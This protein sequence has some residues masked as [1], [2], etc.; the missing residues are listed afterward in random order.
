MIANNIKALDTFAQIVHARNTA[1]KIEEKTGLLLLCHVDVASQILAFCKPNHHLVMLPLFASRKDTFAT[2]YKRACALCPDEYMNQFVLANMVPNKKTSNV[3][4]G[5]SIDFNVMVSKVLFTLWEWLKAL[6]LGL[7]QDDESQ[8]QQIVLLSELHDVPS[9][10]H[11]YPMIGY[12]GMFTM[13][14]LNEKFPDPT[15]SAL[16]GFKQATKLDLECVTS[17]EM[18]YLLVE[19]QLPCVRGSLIPVKTRLHAH[20]AVLMN[21]TC[22]VEENSLKANTLL[23]RPAAVALEQEQLDEQLEAPTLQE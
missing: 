21:K 20:L 6:V 1:P 3:S 23:Y 13:S 12:S 5:T 15:E 10:R 9:V 18:D 19:T 7:V 16:Y 17:C 14:N 22:V 2:F 11:G 8:M 4:F